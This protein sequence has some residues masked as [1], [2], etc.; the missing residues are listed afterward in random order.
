MRTPRAR[1]RNRV[2][3]GRSARDAPRTTEKRKKTKQRQERITSIGNRTIEV[4]NR[5]HAL[6]ENRVFSIRA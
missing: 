1:A 6:I 5:T 3:R 2:H 4:R